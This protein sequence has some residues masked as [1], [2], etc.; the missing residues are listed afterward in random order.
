MT[1]AER[2]R[3]PEFSI[4]GVL[5]K[6][7][8]IWGRSL[9]TL[10]VLMVIIYSP[11]IV[12]QALRIAGGSVPAVVGG[13]G[14]MEPGFWIERL[15]N[16]LSTAAVIYTVFQRLRGARAGIGDSLRIC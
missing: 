9:P 4:G 16:A 1:R 5:G 2:L 10:T 14:L 7:F 8:A 12:Y 3:A 11:L 15:L 13:F 6:G